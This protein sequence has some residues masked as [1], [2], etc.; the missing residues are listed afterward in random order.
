MPLSSSTTHHAR[1]AHQVHTHH[2]HHAAASGSPPEPAGC[3][4]QS[5]TKEVGATVS[6]SY[7]TSSITS[8]ASHAMH[9]AS[10]ITHHLCS[11]ELPFSRSRWSILPTR[12]F[13]RDMSA[14]H[15]KPALVTLNN[16]V[17]IIILSYPSSFAPSYLSR[18][19]TLSVG[20]FPFWEYEDQA[21]A[22]AAAAAAVAVAAARLRRQTSSSTRF[23]H[24]AL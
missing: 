4:L 5:C 15:F 18:C 2:V 10:R 14:T 17:V 7:H 19:I 1:D 23:L 24:P 20:Y 13:K 22:A 9:H 12:V 3:S 8:N 11:N 16:R 21:A 6:S